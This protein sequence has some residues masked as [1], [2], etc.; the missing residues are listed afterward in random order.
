M[1]KS[2]L[3]VARGIVSRIQRN[4]YEAF[5]VGGCVRDRLMG[6]ACAEYDIASSAPPE[7]IARIFPRVV[8]VGKR[9][10]VMLVIEDGHAVHVATFRADLGY[11]DGRKPSGVRFSSAREDVRRR[12]FTI[13][14][15]LYDPISDRLLDY[16]GGE[17]DIRAGTVRAIGDPA[18]RFDEDRLRLLR[19]VRFA[20]TLGFSIESAT[21]AA[22]KGRAPGIRS[23][24]GERVRDELVKIMI[25]PGAGRGLELLGGT[26]LL[27]VILPEVH[28]MKGVRQ[29]ERL[30]PEG[31]VFA[32]TVRML[33]RLER[34]D[35]VLAFA[36]LLHDVGK[37]PTFSVRDRIRFDGHAAEGAR[38]AREICGRL[39]FPSRERE[40][41]ADCVGNHMA[42]LDVKRMREATLKRLMRRP[43]YSRELEL[44]RL[45][46]L[47]SDRD[48][49]AWEHLVR[50]EKEFGAERI[51][52][53]PLITGRDLIRMGWRE[54]PGIGRALAALEELQLENRISTREE[55]LVWAGK[56]RPPAGADGEAEPRASARRPG[57]RGDGGRAPRAPSAGPGP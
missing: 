13:N 18:V 8:P 19:A 6:R 16:V 1:R 2:E 53:R 21:L 25:G 50:K 31:D 4:G 42:F 55:A 33:D 7:R 51:S 57:A 47:A 27:E 29:D 32:H 14:A 5:F 36:V 38:I 46:C 9:F 3:E 49:S 23:V 34:P 11:R 44:H 22:I 45:D 12:D 26:G 56:M 37:P 10:G 28:A 48:L 54:G 20:S 24:S 41:I 43:T 30:H 15:L 17:A 35:A 40:M 52:P 39:R